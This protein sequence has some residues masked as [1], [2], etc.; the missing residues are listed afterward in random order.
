MR[1][2]H[3]SSET[4]SVRDDLE[5]SNSLAEG[6]KEVESKLEEAVISIIDEDLEKFERI[7]EGLVDELV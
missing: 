6:E 5:D 1:D 2:A 3:Q 4:E 7:Q